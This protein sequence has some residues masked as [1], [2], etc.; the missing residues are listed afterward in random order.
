[1][2]SRNQEKYMAFLHTYSIIARDEASGQLGVAVQSHWF[3]VGVLCPWVE[4]GARLP[5]NPW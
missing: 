5:R 2:E 1:M 4:A 3:A